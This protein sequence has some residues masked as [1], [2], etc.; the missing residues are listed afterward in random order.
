M[1]VSSKVGPGHWRGTYQFKWDTTKADPA[2]RFKFSKSGTA[3]VDIYLEGAAVTVKYSN[4]GQNTFADDALTL[5][6]NIMNG[7]DAT[8]QVVTYTRN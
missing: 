5:N 2:C 8:G 3:T 1:T 4:T 6:G 7:Q